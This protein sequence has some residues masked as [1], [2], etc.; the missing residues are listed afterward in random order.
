MIGFS[1]R[2]LVNSKHLTHTLFQLFWQVIYISVSPPAVSLIMAKIVSFPGC[3]AIHGGYSLNF[4]ISSNVW[5]VVNYAYFQSDPYLDIGTGHQSWWREHGIFCQSESNVRND[6]TVI[7]TVSASHVETDVGHCLLQY[8]YVEV[9][10]AG[11]QCLLAV[12]LNRQLYCMLSTRSIQ[13]GFSHCSAAPLDPCF[14]S[15]PKM[16]ICGQLS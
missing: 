13:S 1:W 11:V 12:S 2:T 10:H 6:S 7:V 9:I 14:Y 15:L 3:H 16:L 5:S 4:L 8:Y